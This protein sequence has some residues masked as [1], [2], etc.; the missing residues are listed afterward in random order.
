MKGRRAKPFLSTPTFILPH[1]RGR[2]FI[3]EKFKYSLLEIGD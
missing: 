1:Q 2:R 3:C